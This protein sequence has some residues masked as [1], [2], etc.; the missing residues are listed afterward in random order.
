MTSNNQPA[1]IFCLFHQKT[2]CGCIS[3]VT[4]NKTLKVRLFHAIKFNEINNKF[5]SDP[6]IK[7]Q[8]EAE[9]DSWR[10]RLEDVF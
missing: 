8:R 9:R 10:A 1:K 5:E 3:L 2:D 7:A 4:D 6:K